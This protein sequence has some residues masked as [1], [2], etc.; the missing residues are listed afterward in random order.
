[1][2]CFQGDDDIDSNVNDEPPVPPT[3]HSK[4]VAKVVNYKFAVALLWHTANTFHFI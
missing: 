3:R 1:L 2:L 4:K